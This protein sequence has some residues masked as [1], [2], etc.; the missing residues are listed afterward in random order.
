MINDITRNKAFYN[1]LQHAILPGESIVMD[2]GAGF[3]LLSMMSARLEANLT[4]AI[5]RNKYITDIGK[6]LIHLNNVSENINVIQAESFY[7][8]IDG[9][10]I[11][12]APDIL[13]S[14]TLDQSI[15]G[16]GFLSSLADLRVRKVITDDTI[17]IPSRGDV[18][19]QL[20][21]TPYS[22][23]KTADIEG[24]NFEI[25]RRYYKPKTYHTYHTYMQYV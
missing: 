9:D 12:R 24:F 15:I 6:E 20:V 10:T 13:V 11:P 18:F 7:V 5:E 21:E 22:L 4:I 23:N 1:A 8:E 2:L 19:M 17:I 14:E 25:L 16:E 3:M